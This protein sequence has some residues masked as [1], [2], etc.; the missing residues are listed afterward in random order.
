MNLA[1]VVNPHTGNLDLNRLRALHLTEL[2]CGFTLA[3]L[4]RF[5]L[6]QVRTHEARP[7]QRTTWSRE[8]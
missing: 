2:S 8:E 5:H 3:H 1:Q 6:A 4:L 7:E